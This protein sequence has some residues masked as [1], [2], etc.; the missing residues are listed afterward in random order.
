VI[1]SRGFDIKNACHQL[2]SRAEDWEF[3]LYR[4]VN[5][6]KSDLGTLAIDTT[7][8]V[9]CDWKPKIRNLL[10]SNR[11]INIA[12]DLV[13]LLIEFGQ[14]LESLEAYHPASDGEITFKEWGK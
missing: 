7:R 1:A 10:F 12:E 3:S 14:A 13:K 6:L 8:V 11:N 9:L 2:W 4:Y 5:I